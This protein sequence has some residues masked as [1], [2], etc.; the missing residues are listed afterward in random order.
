MTSIH[1]GF[2]RYS[3]DLDFSLISCVMYKPTL[4]AIY[5]YHNWMNELQGLH[6]MDMVDID[7]FLFSLGHKWFKHTTYLHMHSTGGISV[8]F[9]GLAVSD[10]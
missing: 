7:T 2:R 5:F 9:Q 8:Q 1:W 4:R 10:I 6:D 3:Y